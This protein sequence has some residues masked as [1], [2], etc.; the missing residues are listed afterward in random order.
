MI[1]NV[2]TKR[3]F[4]EHKFN[5]MKLEYKFSAYVPPVDPY[6]DSLGKL[7]VFNVGNTKEKKKAEKKDEEPIDPFVG[8]NLKLLDPNEKESEI[9][10]LLLRPDMEYRDQL[11]E[12]ALGYPSTKKAMNLS[13][14]TNFEE[15]N[16]D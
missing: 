4:L 7:D 5:N 10:K 2:K 9:R 12:I 11:I 3:G 15:W 8:D 14:S 6:D 1:K 13:D 16:L